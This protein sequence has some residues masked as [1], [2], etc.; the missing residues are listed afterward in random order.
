MNTH[1]Q[2]IFT[3]LLVVIAVFSS[4]E[5]NAKEPKSLFTQEDWEM[6]PFKKLPQP[7]LRPDPN[8]KFYCPNS[9]KTI[10]WQDDRVYSPAVVV[11]DGKVWL[12]TRSESKPWKWPDLPYRTQS[13]N[14]AKEGFTGR[15]GLAWSEDGRH[16]TQ[17]PTPV[18]YPDNSDPMK[19]LEWPLGI[20]DA[21]CVEDPDGTF[22]LYYNASIDH[23]KPFILGVATSKDL[24]TWKK[25]GNVFDKKH[26]GRS[27]MSGSVLWELV[28]GYRRVAK[29]IDGKYWMLFGHHDQVAVSDNL[30]DWEVYRDEKGNT[31]QVWS[32]KKGFSY[33]SGEPGTL[34]WTP[35]GIY[36]MLDGGNAD[37]QGPNGDKSLEKSVWTIG[38][39]LLDPNDITRVLK[40]AEKPF[41]YPQY[42]WEKEHGQHYCVMHDGL[43]YFK[44]QWLLYY[45]ASDRNVGLA[46]YT[47]SRRKGA[48]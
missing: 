18:L 19:K 48:K 38:Q 42:D 22:Y 35:K 9:K 12:L 33:H 8:L 10:A 23:R 31:R 5:S 27:G 17:H 34:R 46:I 6:G 29:K 1:T 20:W 13:A 41:V 28:D 21:R 39:M 7:V 4:R 26:P 16:F 2:Y 32:R 40:R 15:V 47:P 36:F 30:I 43:V 24:F 3:T 45:G 37:H 11:K 25:H 44:G 14:R